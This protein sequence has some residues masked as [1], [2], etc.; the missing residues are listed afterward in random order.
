MLLRGATLAWL[1]GL[2]W[3][4]EA[5]VDAYEDGVQALRQGQA[6][7]AQALLQAASQSAPARVEVWWELGWAAW[8]LEDYPGAIAAWTEVARRAPQHPEVQRRLRAARERLAQQTLARGAAPVPQE[9]TGRS[10]RVVAAGDTMLGS[11]LR[12]GAAGL[13]PGSGEHLLASVAPLFQGADVAFLNLE[14]TLADG[15]PSTKCRPDSAVCYAFRTPTRYTAALQAA[16]IDV[17]SNANNHAM[18]LGPAGLASTLAALDRAGI[19]HASR[20]GDIAWL[21]QDGLRIAVVAAHSGSCCLNINRIDEVQA[22]IALADQ[23]ADLVLFSFHGG[24]EGEGARHVPGEVEIAWGEQRGDVRALARAAVDAGA[25]LVLGHGPHVLRAMEVYRGRLIAY[26]L[27]NFLGYRQFGNVGHLGISAAL[28]VELAANGVL[29]SA[30]LHPLALD[31]DAVPHPDPQ[32]LAIGSVQSLSD[33]DFPDTGV[34]ILPDG[35][36]QWRP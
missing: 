34:Q 3:A 4:G 31:R 11:D 32:R 30:R 2:S 8:V 10:L 21:E 6:A 23:E 15:L 7:Q 17:V 24:A 20:T 26:S 16:G 1:V 33:A 14:G 27:G 25:D 18:D 12:K 36:L 13:A 5:R 9:A 35:R 28:E 22:A 19:A 29:R